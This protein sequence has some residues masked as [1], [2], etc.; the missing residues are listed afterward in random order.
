MSPYRGGPPPPDDEPPP[1][2][3]KSSAT[4]RD[5]VF[6]WTMLGTIPAAA[7]F[8]SLPLAS[9]A[10]FVAGLA[11]GTVAYFTHDDRRRGIPSATS[12][13]SACEHDQQEL[14]SKTASEVDEAERIGRARTSR[15]R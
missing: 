8:V 11:A 5:K 15:L 12:S 6:Y 9:A 1:N 3:R 2:F 4:A 14:R 13:A 7:T 10:F